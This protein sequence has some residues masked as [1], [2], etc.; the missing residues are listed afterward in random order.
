MRSE[1]RAIVVADDDRD[2]LETIT[3][4]VELEGYRVYPARTGSEAVRL[5]EEKPDVDLVLTDIR[6]PEMDGVEALG[7]MKAV[8]PDLPV[9]LMSAYAVHSL[10]DRAFK[11]G[12]YT[13]V[14]KP[15]DM[16][17]VLAL[18]ER[19]L[20]RP[21]ILIVGDESGRTRRI[22]GSAGHGTIAASDSK[23]AKALCAANTID[24][25]VVDLPTWERS[26]SAI[27]QLRK[28]APSASIIAITEPSPLLEGGA[29]PRLDACIARDTA[30]DRLIR[31][32]TDVRG[33]L[34]TEP[35]RA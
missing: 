16:D 9:I 13:L 33:R 31:L 17:Q 7:R 20:E 3:A 22:L 14:R 6:M 35:G 25:V 12:A 1:P 30:P 23:D 29:P 19:A 10:E 15:F 2:M 28:A 26:A 21:S 4:I 34:R 18:I 24:V 5:V 27:R 8:R 11:S 32:I